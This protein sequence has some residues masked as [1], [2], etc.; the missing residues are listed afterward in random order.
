M[1]SGSAVSVH[2]DAEPQIVTAIASPAGRE[3]K[4]CHADPG[5]ARER[6]ADPHAAAEQH[7]Q[8]D[9]QQRR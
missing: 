8:R 9:D 5:D 7:E 3:M 4:S 2:D 6:Q 1:K